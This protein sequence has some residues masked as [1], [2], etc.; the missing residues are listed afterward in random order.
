MRWFF[1]VLLTLAAFAAPASPELEAVQEAYQEAEREVIRARGFIRGAETQVLKAEARLAALEAAI[2]ALASQDTPDPPGDGRVI[3]VAPGDDISEA[4]G[5]LRDGYPDQLLFQRG[6]VY[7]GGLGRWE[8]SGRSEDEPM[9]IGAYG[10]PEAPLPLFL[11]DGE[12]T[13]LVSPSGTEE[14]SH[15]VF[16]DLHAM[17][18]HRNPDHPDFVTGESLEVGVWWSRPGRDINFVNLRLEYFA[19]NMNLF[20]TDGLP[21]RDVL[22]KDCVFLNAYGDR[23]STGHSQGLYAKA[24]EDLTIDG[25]YFDHNGWHPTAPRAERTGYNHNI[26][27][28]MCSDVSVLNNVLSR[29]SYMGLKI[30]SDEE[31]AVANVLIEGNLFTGNLMGITA[32]G[33]DNHDTTSL[34][35]QNITVRR[36]VFTNHGGTLPNGTEH[37]HAVKLSQVG[38]ALVSEN[39]LVDLGTEI[40]RHAFSI[41]TSKPHQNI[42]LRDNVLER[43]PMA[44]GREALT[45]NASSDELF[46][47][48]NRV[49]AGASTRSLEAFEGPLEDAAEWLL[50]GITKTV[51][52]YTHHPLLLN[53]YPE[54]FQRVEVVVD[55]DLQ[56]SDEGS[57]DTVA[58]ALAG[59]YEGRLVRKLDRAVGRILIDREPLP[60]HPSVVGKYTEVVLPL[61]SHL[62]ENRPDLE[63]WLYSHAGRNDATGY[64]SRMEEVQRA[65][66]AAEL[67]VDAIVPQCYQSRNGRPVNDWL[68]GVIERSKATGLKVIPIIWAW[69][70]TE[71][72]QIVPA[73]PE[74]LTAICRTIREAGIT[75]VVVWVHSQ[76]T[77]D[78]P[79]LVNNINIILESFS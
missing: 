30:R 36:N 34:V 3:L 77:L 9:V 33:D 61:T 6:G 79:V 25:C 12:R 35:I 65:L 37:G 20:Q 49:E 19:N 45:N 52:L 43:W 73:D 71:D 63:I 57:P 32:S 53:A 21:L 23:V 10:D 16:R 50:D 69:A 54:R 70:Q 7:R 44:R 41:S 11:T 24:V 62:R 22:V 4:I 47:L 66:A 8:K 15:L 76:A 72:G 2:E 40:N 60:Y 27:L 48:D 39:L 18:N 74:Q 17:C 59:G 75:E 67:P 64:T 46:L 1:A 26:Y 5:Q 13:G 14:L 42:V 55:I 68:P 28:S 58:T 78:D 29:G 51:S 38:D 31:G 56:G